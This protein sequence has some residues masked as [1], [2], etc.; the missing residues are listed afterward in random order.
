MNST[1][2]LPKLL[3]EH[4]GSLSVITNLLLGTQHAIEFEVASANFQSNS[5]QEGQY[6]YN[7]FCVPISCNYSPVKLFRQK[8]Q[9]LLGWFVLCKSC[10]NARLVSY[11]EK[12][13]H[14]VDYHGF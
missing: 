8:N 5:L 12:K 11:L 3:N 7:P 6:S 9:L 2:N 1:E 4:Y 10:P 14:R 13:L